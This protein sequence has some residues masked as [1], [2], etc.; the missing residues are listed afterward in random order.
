MNAYNKLPHAP[1][2]WGELIDKITILEIKK[3]YL[4]HPAALQNVVNELNLLNDIY[5]SLGEAISAITELKDQLRAVNQTLWNIEDEIRNKERLK[6]FD[7]EFISLARSVYITNDRRAQL[8]KE[9]NIL[10]S[11]ELLEEKSYQKYSE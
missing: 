3:E 2:S 10:L 4:S 8:K 7:D 6:T 11:S 5:A 1:I 9:I